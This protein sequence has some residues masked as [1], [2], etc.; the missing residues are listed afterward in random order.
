MAD[1]KITQLTA[2]AS[3][4]SD[5]LIPTVNDPGGTPANKK[6]TIAN[7]AT[8][9]FSLLPAWSTYTDSSTGWSATPTTNVARWLQ[10]GKTA[11]LD[12]DV[13]G[14][15]NATSGGFTLP[16]TPKSTTVFLTRVTDNGAVQ[17]SPGIAVLTA[18][19]TAVVLYKTI[20]AGAFTGSGTKEVS[21]FGAVVEIQ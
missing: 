21:F 7:L 16:F 8:L 13:T 20:A 12:Y 5:D 11:Y 3:P 10:V 4:T 18:G 19:S 14:T 2:D 1:L 9:V 17:N 15:S 6:V